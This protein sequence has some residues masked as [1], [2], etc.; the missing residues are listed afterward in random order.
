MWKELGGTVI[1]FA[2]DAAEAGLEISTGVL[3]EIHG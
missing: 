1:F 3:I 2:L